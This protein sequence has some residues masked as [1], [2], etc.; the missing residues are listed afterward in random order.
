MAIMKLSEAR[1]C[2]ELEKVLPTGEILSPNSS[3]GRFVALRKFQVSRIN[4]RVQKSGYDSP[5]LIF[6]HTPEPTLHVGA[7]KARRCLL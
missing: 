4:S 1:A 3:C 6:V 7:D 5:T 2:N